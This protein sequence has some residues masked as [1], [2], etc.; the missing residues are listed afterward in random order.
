MPRLRLRTLLVVSILALVLGSIAA[1]G[2]VA[3]D[4]LRRMAEEQARARVALAGEAA[5]R[6]LEHHGNELQTAARVLIEQPAMPRWLDGAHTAELSRFLETYRTSRGL[7]GCGVLRGGQGALGSGPPEL[8]WPRIAAA[9][10]STSTRAILRQAEAGPLLLAVRSTPDARTGACGVACRRLDATLMGTLGAQVGM[11]VGIRLP[12]LDAPDDD[13]VRWTAPLNGP[14]GDQAGVLEVALTRSEVEAPLRQLRGQLL[15]L[16][17]A[18]AALATALG[19]LVARRVGKPID[20]LTEASVR[21]GA[22]DLTTP[23]PRVPGAEIGALSTAMEDMRDRILQL[24]TELRRRQAQAE[25]VLAGVAEGVFAVD[26]ERVIRYVNPQLATLLGI[27]PEA[28]VGRFC[29]DVLRPLPAGRGRSTAA[30]RPC[31]EDCPILLARFQGSVRAVEHLQLADGRLRSMVITS[32]SE[33]YHQAA[34]ERLQY[35]VMRDE[36][37]VEASRRMRDAVLANISHEFKTPLAAQLA[38]LELLRDRLPDLSPEELQALVRS[39]ERGTLRLT[40][41]IDNLLESTRID[42]GELSIRRLPVLLDQVVEEAI[43]LMAPLVEQR[44][45]RLDVEVNHPLSE[46]QG[47]AQRLTQVLVNL[48]SNAN[49]FAPEGSTIRVGC[50]PRDGQVAL[51][52]EDEG[53]GLPADALDAV[54][55][56]FVRSVGQE[57]EQSG[58]GLGLWVVKSI[59]QRHGGRVVLEGGARR[60]R[61]SVLLPTND[62]RRQ[63]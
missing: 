53:Q 43:E 37:E 6:A 38:S 15:A 28:A 23:V 26:R 36:T 63:A 58:M 41:L 21:I 52:V 31:Q 57:P 3:L 20:Q 2:A 56:P 25:A 16:G 7:E 9:L 11:P 10:D 30:G 33:P 35:Q 34:D 19:L 12:G 45:Q 47:D 24:A 60:T 46:I 5:L 17:L 62:P 27:A 61:V 22:G 49:K 42:A 1:V 50:G 44:G 32:A 51:W 29:G 55:R 48:L 13:R 18:I 59:V 14:Q 39:L 8:P 40:R 4:L 54:F